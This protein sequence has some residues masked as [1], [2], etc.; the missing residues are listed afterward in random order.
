MLQMLSVTDIKQKRIFSPIS[1]PESLPVASEP[2]PVSHEKTKMSGQDTQSVRP[3]E[4]LTASTLAGVTQHEETA[5]HSEACLVTDSVNASRSQL[6]VT[7]ASPAD[8]GVVQAHDAKIQQQV[9]AGC[10]D[11]EAGVDLPVET[12]MNVNGVTASHTSTYQTDVVYKQETGSDD[13]TTRYEQSAN[14]DSMSEAFISCIEHSPSSN[15]AVFSSPKSNISHNRNINNNMQHE[16]QQGLRDT[17]VA[18]AETEAVI[19]RRCDSEMRETES[20]GKSAADERTDKDAVDRDGE[21]R[22]IVD[23]EEPQEGDENKHRDSEI[24]DDDVDDGDGDV[25]NEDKADQSITEEQMAVERQENQSEAA[26]SGKAKTDSQKKKR[27]SEQQSQ[28]ATVDEKMAS[29]PQYNKP[30]AVESVKAK[31]DSQK[32]KKSE[33]EC[34]KSQSATVAKSDTSAKKTEDVESLIIRKP[35]QRQSEVMDTDK[36]PE[37]EESITQSATSARDNAAEADIHQDRQGRSTSDT[38]NEQQHA[39]DPPLD[40]DTNNGEVCQ[41]FMSSVFY[42]HL[43]LFCA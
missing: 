6:S 30:E 25:D 21:T 43:L 23:S 37:C 1:G 38:C 11:T 42:A 8:D 22:K 26:A 40:R 19:A 7:S 14:S 24:D 18:S 27:K 31:T 15:D 13:S 2:S 12:S 36:Q 10:R 35:P 39:G 16:V 34:K 41:R 5:E 17:T 28:S 29:E 20:E 4:N 32:K 9:A 3:H 33:Q